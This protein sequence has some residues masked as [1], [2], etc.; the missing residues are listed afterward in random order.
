[1]IG[2]S[3]LRT[4]L[5]HGVAWNLV[6][7]V[8]NQG[9]TFVVNVILAHILGVMV[10]G[11]YAMV[12]STVAVATVLAQI[13][14]GYTATKYIAEFRATDPAR[15]GRLL[16]LLGVAALSMATLTAAS[17]LVASGFL[18]HSL[19]HQADL[20]PALAIASAA[21]L[22]G[23]IS[24]FLMGALAGLESYRTLGLA[25]ITSGLVYVATCIAGAKAGG[26]SGA[27]A[28]VALSAL[29]QSAVLW[30][31]VRMEARRNGIAV[32][33]VGVGSEVDIILRFAIPA[34][35]PAFIALPAV[36]IGNAFLVNQEGGYA[37]L[38]LFTA[39][40]SFRII[41]LFLPN[42]WNSVTMSLLNHQK[43]LRDVRRYRRL[44]WVNL[45]ATLGTVL[46]GAAIV[47]VAGRWLLLWFGPAFAGGYTA[48]LLLMVVTLPEGASTA[49]LQ[50]IQSR[51]RIWWYVG[52]VVIPCY[53]TL[54]GV[55]W[56]LTPTYGA[57]G[58]A[59]AHL[60]GW[61][62]AVAANCV[63]VSRLGVNLPGLSRAP[64]SG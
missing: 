44:F 8:F 3:S 50:I 52:A 43:G 4:R 57:V 25:G 7:V 62:I 46:V 58:L 18:A 19:L 15:A 11:K 14:T 54:V 37:L 51:E 38:A 34:A 45:G 56:W 27:V 5:A 1:M 28:G 39:A 13:S 64:A 30:Q 17:M 41:V 29:L 21:V 33:F 31:C 47:A 6:A 55:A 2:T 9:S 20:A 42:I 35:L 24:G 36:W 23:A 12:Q 40:N 48:L 63:I 32:R 22:F 60:A 61:L 49:L 10:F 26:L 53:A 16:G 59:W